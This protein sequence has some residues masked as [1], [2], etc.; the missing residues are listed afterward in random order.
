MTLDDIRRV[1]EKY[2]LP[3]FSPD[4]SIGAVSVSSGKADEVEKG[5]KDMGFTVER[6]EL[7]MLNGV[8]G[9]SEGEGSGSEGS[10]ASGSESESGDED[11]SVKRAKHA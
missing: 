6:K 4:T 5:F 11:E 1:I 2:L 9:E 3:L 10:E 8:E 7:P